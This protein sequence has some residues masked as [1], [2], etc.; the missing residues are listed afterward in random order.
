MD[1]VIKKISEIETAASSVME[2]ANVRKKAFAQEIEEKTA[3]FDKELE[4]QTSQKL[5]ELRARME[6]EMNAKLSKQKAD[7]EAMLVRMEKNYED[8]H[9]EY[10][11]TLFRSLIGE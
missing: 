9:A 5:E 3:A 10:A 6:I 8:H 1:T 4:A 2:D 7:A 11:R